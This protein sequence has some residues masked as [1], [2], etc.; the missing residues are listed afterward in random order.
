M[1]GNPALKQT[2]VN[3]VAFFQKFVP[4]A[5]NLALVVGVVYFLF[6]I[7]M[8][9]TQ[10]ISSGGDKQA[11][12]AARSKITNAIIGMVILFAVYAVLNLIAYFFGGITILTL[13]IAPLVI[14]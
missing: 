10:W 11:V 6:N 1:I 12:E 5:I 4:A 8:G 7:I 14:Q 9:A 3:G 13:D 2:N